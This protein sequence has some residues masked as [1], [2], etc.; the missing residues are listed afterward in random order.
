MRRITAAEA[1]LALLALTAAA[2]SRRAPAA[3]PGL[4]DLPEI[5]TVVRRDLPET[6][7]A[8]GVASGAELEVTVEAGDARK[9]RPGQAAEAFVLPSTSAVHCRVDRLMR[10]ASAETGQAVVWL[11]AAAGGRVPSDDFVFARIS[12]GTRRGVAVAPRSA[13]MIR[14]G[15]PMAVRVR[16]GA[17]G[18]DAYEP[19]P[20]ELGD[21][22][23]GEVEIRS[24][25][26][27]G[28]RVVA[29]GGI[30]FLDPGFKAAGGD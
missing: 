20:V 1:G 10:D 21:A 29:G 18:A 14:D 11:R 2:C 6:V 23:G 12:V 28:D 30:G 17:D 7:P 9:V 13:V 22:A 3:V 25:L 4:A 16:A 5:T 19:V 24:G 15:R 26:T 27:T 8:Y